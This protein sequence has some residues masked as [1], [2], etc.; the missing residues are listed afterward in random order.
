M[1][2][3]PSTVASIVNLADGPTALIVHL[4]RAKLT[5]RCGDRLQ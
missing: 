5:T 3:W 2:N 1:I 4:R